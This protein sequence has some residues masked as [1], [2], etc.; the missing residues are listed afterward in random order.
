M[1]AQTR[2]AEAA[3]LSKADVSFDVK[4]TWL[5]IA[6][7]FSPLAVK[8][9]I[10]VSMGFVLLNISKENGAPATKI[11]P[12][13]GMEPRSLTRMLKRLE[14]M[15]LI[16]RQPDPQD[17]RSVR[18]YLTEKGLA[19]RQ[20]ARQDVELFNEE[21]KRA[22]GPEKLAL[23]FEVLEEMHLVIEKHKSIV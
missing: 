4:V 16:V 10:S 2:K 23:F 20:N 6:K 8:N 15:K 19:M 14:E 22:I 5:A 1:K 11:A 13:L 21:V 17:G 7:M 12:L 18:I 9:G 3:P